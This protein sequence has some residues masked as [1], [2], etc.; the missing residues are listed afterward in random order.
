VQFFL[1]DP[2]S[3]DKPKV[4]PQTAALHE[5]NLTIFIHSPYQINI[6]SLNNRLRIP[7]RTAVINHAK[8][9]AE[10]GATGLIVHGGHV[11]SDDEIDAGLD[12]WRKLFERQADKG[13]FG[14]PILVET[15]RAATTRDGPPLG[16]AGQ[17]VGPDRRVRRRVCLDTCHAFAAARTWWTW[18]SGPARSPAGSTWCT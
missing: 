14:V 1:C 5:R 4:H 18:S 9:A 10:V 3:W 16:H 12:N 6:A 2:Q 7:S 13:G 15:P 17:T 8:V 11:T